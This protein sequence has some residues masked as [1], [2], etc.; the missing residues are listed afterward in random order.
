MTDVLCDTSVV[1]KW[2]HD[3]GESEVAEARAILAAHRAGELTAVVLDLT[4]YELGNVLLR[5]LRWKATDVADQLDDL[6]AVCS[7]ATPTEPELRLA[8]ELAETH[9]L[10]FYDAAYA[11]VAGGRGAALATADRH[12][13]G[14]GLGESSAALATRLGLTGAV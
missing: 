8:A 5:S 2:F 14:S 10:T 4:R 1:L 6:G 7:I 13:L 3:E 12:L 11:G 9:G